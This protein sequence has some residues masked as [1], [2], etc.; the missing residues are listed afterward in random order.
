MKSFLDIDGIHLILPQILVQQMVIG[1]E[2]MFGLVLATINKVLLPI[3]C[4]FVCSL[5]YINPIQQPH[6]VFCQHINYPPNNLK[7]WFKFK[8]KFN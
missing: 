4:M 5:I 1:F 3:I 7:N 2:K 6:K 8:Y